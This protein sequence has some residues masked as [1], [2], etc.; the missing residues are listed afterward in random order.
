MVRQRD[1]SAVVRRTIL[2]YDHANHRVP[3]PTIVH[4]K[5]GVNDPHDNPSIAM[6]EAGYIW[7]FVSGRGRGRSGF[8]YRAAELYSVEDFQLVKQLEITY[9]QPW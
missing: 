9:P 3:R 2:L 7:V 8:I 5:Q 6:D 4:D 1:L